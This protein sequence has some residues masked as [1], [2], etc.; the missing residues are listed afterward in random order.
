MLALTEVIAL[1]AKLKSL[2]NKQNHPRQAKGDKWFVNTH[3]R[4]FVF[5]ARELHTFRVWIRLGTASKATR[6]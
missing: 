1:S 3:D 5:G 2:A 4:Y 6:R